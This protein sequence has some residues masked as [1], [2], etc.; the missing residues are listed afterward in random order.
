MEEVLDV[1]GVVEGCGRGGGFGDSFAVGGFAGVDTLEDAEAAEVGEGDLQAA[2]GLGAGVVVL[3][4]AGLAWGG[5]V[6]MMR[7][8]LS[9]MLLPRFWVMRAMAANGS[10]RMTYLDLSA[11]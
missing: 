5:L 8:V 1:F 7:S 4:C 2:D 6:S 3:C 10:G 11:K 9:R